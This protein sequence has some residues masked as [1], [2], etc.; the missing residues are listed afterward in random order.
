MTAIPS[1][2]SSNALHLELQM[3]DSKERTDEIGNY[4]SEAPY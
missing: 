1:C 4:S 2:G 3:M